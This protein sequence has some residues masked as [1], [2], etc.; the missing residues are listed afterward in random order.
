MILHREPAPEEVKAWTTA[1][2][3]GESRESVLRD[4]RNSPE[5]VGMA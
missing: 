2:E 1:M 5:A 4:I 3:K